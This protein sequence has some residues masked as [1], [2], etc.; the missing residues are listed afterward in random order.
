MEY[1]D[2]F[3]LECLTESVLLKSARSKDTNDIARADFC[4]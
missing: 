1:V 3:Q 2:Y 4:F